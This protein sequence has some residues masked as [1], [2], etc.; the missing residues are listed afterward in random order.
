MGRKEAKLPSRSIQ[1]VPAMEKN[2]EVAYK[3]TTN[4]RKQ[5]LSAADT[6]MLLP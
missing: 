2:R 4:Q 6:I 1:I 3:A 5:L